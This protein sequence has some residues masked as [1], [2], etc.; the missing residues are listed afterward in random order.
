MIR[1]LIV[2]LAIAISFV[3]SGNAQCTSGTSAGSIIVT[4]SWQFIASVSGGTYYTFTAT[5]NTIYN[6]SFCIADGGFSLYD[7]EITILNPAGNPVNGGFS[8][9]ACLL[10]ASVSWLC[11]ISATY[12]VLVTKKNCS[13]QSNLGKLAYRSKSIVTCPSGLGAGVTNVGSLPYSS[14]SGSTAGAVNNLTATNIDICGNS[15]YLFGEDRVWIFTPLKSGTVTITLT[16][17]S[18]KAGLYLYKGCPLPY[19]N[20]VCIGSALGG[21]NPMLTACVEANVTYYLIVDSQSNTSNFSYANLSISAPTAISACSIGAINSIPLL[22]YSSPRRTTCGK[23]DDISPSNSRICGNSSYLK[24]EDEVFSFTPTSSGNI[25]VTINSSHSFSGLFLFDGCPL[26]SYCNGNAVNCISSETNPSGSKSLCGYVVAGTTYYLV[27]DRWTDCLPYSINISAPTVNLVGATCAN[28]VII[29]SLPYSAMKENTACMGDNY[30]N[31]TT[32]TCGSLYESGE[33][34]VYKY[35]ASSAECIAITLSGASDNSIGYTVFNGVPGNPGVTC[36]GNAGGANSGVLNG[37]VTLPVAGD[38]YI[39]VDTWADPRNVQFSISIASYGTAISNDTYCTAQ[40]IPIGISISGDNGCS[41]GAGE[42]QTTACW[43]TPNTLN[44][45]WYSFIAPAS[46]KAIIRTTPGTLKNTQ[47]A[48]YSGSCGGGVTYL[49]CNDN[50]AACGA[51]TTSM[52]QITINSL[53]PNVNYFIAVDGANSSIGTFGIIVIDG[54]AI[55]PSIYGQECSVPLPVCDT[56]V[57]VGNPG[58]QLF[59]NN[60]DF[61]GTGANCLDGGERGSAWY[62]I[63]IKNN[64]FLDFT[65]IPNDWD[66]APSIEGT[67]YDFAIWKTSGNGATTCSLIS[68][69]ATPLRCNYSYLSVTGLFGSTDFTENPNYPGFGFAFMS[70]IPVVTGEKYLLVISNYSNS[71]SGFSLNF[72]DNSPVDYEPSGTNIVWTG[73]SDNDWFKRSNWGGCPV[74]TCGKNAIVVAAPVNQPIINTA[75]ANVQSLSITTGATLTINNSYGINVCGDF[76]NSGWLNARS[77]STVTFNGAGTQTISGNL[78]GASAFSNMTTTKKSGSVVLSNKIEVK[79]NFTISNSTSTFNGNGKAI[80][81]R[82]NFNNVNGI[83]DAGTGGLLSFIGNANQTYFNAGTLNSVSLDKAGSNGVTLN[84]DMKIGTA[85]ILSLNNGIIKTGASREVNVLNDAT[86]AVS[87]GTNTSYVEGV[88]RRSLPPSMSA[89]SFDFPVGHITA[90]YQ[91]INLAMFNGVD[92]SIASLRMNFE[93]YSTSAPGPM[94]LDPSCGVTY[95]DVSLDNGYWNVIPQGT[96]SAQ[97]HVTLFNK[98]YTNATNAFSVML[99][100]NTNGWQVPA[101]NSGGCLTSPVTSVLRNGLQLNFTSGLPFSFGTAQ[102][103]SALP[104]S[105]LSFIA[106]PEANTIIIQWTTATETNNRGFDVQKS[107]NGKEF[108]TIGWVDGNGST[109]N[110]SEYSFVDKEVRANVVYYYRLKQIDHD[111]KECF[112]KVVAAV[113]KDNSVVAYDVFPNPYKEITQLRYIITRPATVTIEISDMLGKV[114]KKYQQGLQDEGTYSIP[115]S[116]KQNGYPAGIYNLT[117]WCDDQ[118][119]TVK[120]NEN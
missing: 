14:G 111:G 72:G 70:Q 47:I 9:D 25:L 113:M 90:G 13:I 98:N 33:D 26:A 73:A 30:N 29:S 37:S 3:S 64:G 23:G 82:G 57:A 77:G 54:N 27:V 83:F 112:S 65:I 103:S 1:K 89:R 24:G 119:Y 63:Q 19:N 67:D 86:N 38:Y 66:G 95:S 75:G 114:V 85:G 6:F 110:I 2:I 55:L 120:L 59:G 109:V 43:T 34:K 58:F 84:T 104:V 16:T 76:N 39:L 102:G 42:P 53:L 87:T 105:M 32:G 36:I 35:T 117:L 46:G 10:S 18:N 4:N 31:F 20:S 12:R 108:T 7:N 80:Y 49:A 81:L 88:L 5:A 101:V 44:T 41:S 15:N 51:T 92:P 17:T 21:S 11:D 106:K 78:E 74:P 116:A 79:G 96:G 48:V 62:E 61:N 8:Q 91:R 100:D 69:G 52:S 107:T 93:A 60:C 50:A 118:R 115:F 68:S 71:I 94:G 56:T 40:E 99:K 28:P 22:P 97:M 45:V